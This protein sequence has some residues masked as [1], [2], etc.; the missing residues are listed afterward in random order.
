M[1]GNARLPPDA[2][3]H[4]EIGGPGAV[5]QHLGA[6]GSERAGNGGAC[7]LEQGIKPTALQRFATEFGD[8][9]ELPPGFA[10]APL[11]V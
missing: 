9:L 10:M 7:P 2:G 8:Q 3:D 1:A 5:A 11:G 4:Q 6:R